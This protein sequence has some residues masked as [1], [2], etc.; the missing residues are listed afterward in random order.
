MNNRPITPQQSECS[1]FVNIVLYM[2]DSSREKPTLILVCGD[3]GM[4]EQGSHGGSS[5]SETTIP[6]VL[7]SSAF[8]HGQGMYGQRVGLE[9]VWGDGMGNIFK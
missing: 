3:H 8:Q 7:L 5:P 9:G 2:Q 4:S 6:I 1:A